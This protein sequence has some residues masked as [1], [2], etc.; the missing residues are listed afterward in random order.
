MND[1]TSSKPEPA[2]AKAPAAAKSRPSG[3]TTVL[4]LAAL[5]VAILAAAG[6]GYLWYGLQYKQKLLTA[7]LPT[8]VTN[9]D[10]QVK[11]LT[12]DQNAIQDALAGVKNQQQTLT[13]S[14]QQLNEQLGKHRN[15]WMLEE[16]R[17]LLL[18]ANHRLKLGGDVDTAIAALQAADGRLEQLADPRLLDVRK[19]IAEEITRLETLNRPDVPGL[20]L[21]LEG[22]A[23]AVD[24]LPLV[25]R[26]HTVTETQSAPKPAANE[27][28]AKK[29]AR[30]VWHDLLGLVRVRRINK[31]QPPL[32]PPPL[33][34]FLRENL[35][36][37]LNEAQ[38]ALLQRRP[39]VY[40]TDLERAKAWIQRYFDPQA[41]PV[42]AVI[43]EL[44][45]MGKVDIAPKMPDIS[46][47]LEA[48]DKHLKAQAGP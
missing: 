37:S 35:R 48:L 3:I 9:L 44:D 34:Y 32:L 28:T 22:L 6:V 43:K 30:Q 19:L 10:A 13:T 25:T 47:S 2:P 4:A 26:P 24:G 16:V 38:L 23:D 12:Q 40:T 42:K 20:A 5:I 41:A 31:P 8:Q 15:D 39:Q 14:L 27:N 33:E 17:Q 1:T 21:R 18:L 11:T 7:G 45:A 36:L 29:V 46:A